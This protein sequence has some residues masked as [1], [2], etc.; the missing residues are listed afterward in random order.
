MD[1]CKDSN[2]PCDTLGLASLGSM[3]DPE[4]SCNINEDSGL[5]LAFTIA[6]EMGHNF[7]AEHDTPESECG[8]LK[9]PYLMNTHSST[10]IKDFV[11]SECSR[12]EITAFLE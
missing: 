5:T 1:I 2:S 10:P 7:N 9:K 6:H 12:R 11:W 8:L 3:C 4:R